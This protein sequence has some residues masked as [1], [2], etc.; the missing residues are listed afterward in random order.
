MISFYNQKWRRLHSEELYDPCSSP[1][2]I[3]MIKSRRMRWV[4]NV[5]CIQERRG[6]YR[7]LVGK[8]DGTRHLR[9]SRCRWEDTIK[10]Y[11]QEVGLGVDWIYLAQ[12]RHRWQAVVNAVMNL[13]V[14]IKCV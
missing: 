10:I 14:P 12:D 6:V 7:A 1:N 2:V 11:L 9:R 3:L 8:P 4:G 13:C 5:A